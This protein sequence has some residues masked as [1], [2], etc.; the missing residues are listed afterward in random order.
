MG[1][2][3]WRTHEEILAYFDGLELLDPGLVPMP[4][5]RPGPDDKAAPGITYHT[6]VGGVGRKV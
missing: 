4:E 1:T 2:G 3:R 6:F 5:W